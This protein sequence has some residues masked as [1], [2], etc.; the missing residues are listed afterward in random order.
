[1]PIY[2]RG[3]DDLFIYLKVNVKFYFLCSSRLFYLGKLGKQTYGKFL[4]CL[5]CGSISFH[6]IV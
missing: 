1:M 5:L 4:V 2:Y 6:Y 3:I